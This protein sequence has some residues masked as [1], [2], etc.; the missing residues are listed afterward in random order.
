MTTA[1]VSPFPTVLHLLDAACRL[2]PDRT[3]L[4]CDDTRLSYRTYRAC[5]AALAAELTAGG[6]RP[7]DR[8]VTLMA[9]SADAAIASF[10]VH[11]AGAQLV[12]LNPAYT[13]AELG[14]VL[15]DAQPV[16][17]LHDDDL[18]ARLDAAAPAGP[19]RLPVGPVSRRLTTTT[20]EDPPALVLPQPDWPATLQ[21]TGGTTGR[22][23]GV[24]LT[25]GAISIN[26]AQREALLP[27][28]DG[29]QVLC[30]TPLFHVYAVSMGL[31]L[32]ANCKGTLH[33]VRKFDSAQ[34]LR[35]ITDNQIGFLSASPTIFLGLMRDPSFTTAD[36]SSLR[37][38]SSGSAALPEDTL[39]RWEAVTNCP[40]CEGYGQTEAG[41]V[42]TYNPLAGVRKPGSVGVPV[43]GTEVQI[44]DPE[45][46][47][48]V[49]PPGEIGE[50]R[51]RGPQIM[52][53]YRNRPDETAAALRA[54]WLH[55]GD[56]GR[57]D[58]EGYLTICD[59]KKDMVVTAGYN[60]YP[61][62][63]EELLF[64]LPGVA[65]AAVVGVPDPYRGEALVALVV[66]ADPPPDP[67]TIRA[68][69]A[70][71]LT[72]YKWPRELRLVSAL[73]K[74]AVAK[75]DKAAIRRQL[76]A[77][78]PETP[79]AGPTERPNTQTGSPK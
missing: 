74:T 9:N 45:T 15:A 63:I 54:G 75:T 38:C 36:L 6:V 76:L 62:E 60:V 13:V 29:E 66:P 23:K 56:I 30:I 79:G 47:T 14:P 37:V 18:G 57:L 35:Y 10:A 40:V 65:D 61:R 32:A 77:E 48:R 52:I 19:L 8:V 26:V 55:T 31:Y 71:R 53:G 58:A 28:R 12:P 49:L 25:H 72:R 68:H 24:I 50:I 4:I 16:A 46:G 34:V 7:G 41:P 2:V 69:L 27:T 78:P 3:A 43:P 11:A 67:E 64:A 21:Y 17:I 70:E 39:R 33:V 42:L 20:L 44:V 5:I 1:P 22:P 73:P 51:A 59:R